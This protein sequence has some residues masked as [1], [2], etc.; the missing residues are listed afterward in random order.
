M[1]LT[2]TLTQFCAIGKNCDI[3]MKSIHQKQVSVSV[4]DVLSLLGKGVLLSSLFIFPHAGLGIGAIY[5]FY[6]SIKREKDFSTWEKFNLSRLR[7]LL[8][9][10]RRQKLISIYH[11]DGYEVMRLTK[12]GRVKILRYKLE[13]MEIERQTKWDYKWR[14]II[15]DITQFKHRQQSAFRRILKQLNFFPL[16]KS[17]YLTPYPCN[18][19]IDFLREYFEVGEAVIYIIAEKIENDEVYRKYFGL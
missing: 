8:R 10:L 14:L 2:I 18:K 7:F 11:Q 6:Q 1:T 19:E 5:N 4:S 3:D 17:V 13:E 12:K 15:Y 9:R 16:Q